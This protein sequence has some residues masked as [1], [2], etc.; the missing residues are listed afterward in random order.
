MAGNAIKD[1]ER[2][3]N[4]KV[5][6]MLGLETL[7]HNSTRKDHIDSIA[8]FAVPYQCFNTCTRIGWGRT[9]GICGKIFTWDRRVKWI[10]C[11]HFCSEAG[12]RQNLLKWVTCMS[13]FSSTMP[14]K[15]TQTS[16]ASSA[17]LYCALYPPTTPRRSSIAFHVPPLVQKCSQQ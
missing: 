13:P 2:T 7:K 15:D 12:K 14:A 11:L 3:G 8:D 10:G 17:V 6:P 1:Y 9:K 4:N 5:K 16:L